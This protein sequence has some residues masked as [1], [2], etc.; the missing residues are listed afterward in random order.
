MYRRPIFK[1]YLNFCSKVHY[2]ES[3]SILILVKPL[4]GN[5]IFLSCKVWPVMKKKFQIMVKAKFLK[6]IK[7]SIILNKLIF[8]YQNCKIIEVYDFVYLSKST[9]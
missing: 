5:I 9:L 3:K 8:I 4:I 2:E 6:S 1:T 7:Q